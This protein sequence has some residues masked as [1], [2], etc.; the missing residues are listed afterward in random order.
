M[1]GS[2]LVLAG[3]PVAA[4][5]VT[6]AALLG[7]LTPA[8]GLPWPRRATSSVG[9]SRRSASA[10]SSRRVGGGWTRRGSGDRLELGR[11]VVA[12]EDL[13]VAR[14]SA[15]FVCV[16]RLS[17]SAECS[18]TRSRPGGRRR[19]RGA[20]SCSCAG[21]GPM[22]SS[23]ATGPGSRGDRQPDR[24]R[25]RARG[26]EVEVSGRVVFSV[27]RSRS[28][29]AA[30]AWT[31]CRR[32]DRGRA[33]GCPARPRASDRPR[34]CGRPRWPPGRCAEHTLARG[35]CWSSRRPRSS[36]RKPNPAEA[37]RTPALGA[38]ARRPDGGGRSMQARAH[39]SAP[40]RT[41]QRRPRPQNREQP[42]VFQAPQRIL[43]RRR[44]RG[45]EVGEEMVVELHCG[46]SGLQWGTHA[47][48]T[49]VAGL[50]PPSHPGSKLRPE[51][52]EPL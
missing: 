30:L 3:W 16:M 41:L 32:A 37:S 15:R 22:R 28:A 35:W 10:W 29:I 25:D 44:Q 20:W 26:G 21:P 27:V 6:A 8:G 40:Q 39:L 36:R 4:A 38:V 34:N 5:A 46:E 19:P 51:R 12:L 47:I 23:R 1:I 48:W 11:A 17:A 14:A 33:A 50:L 45:G 9:R 52:S 18:R 42:R 43:A 13:E 24:E 2:A 49:R 7:G 31:H